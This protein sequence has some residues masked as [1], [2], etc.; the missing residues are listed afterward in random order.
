MQRLIQEE[1][2]QLQDDREVIAG[3]LR[4]ADK[5][6]KDSLF[7]PVN[8][9]RLIRTHIRGSSIDTV[10]GV[11]DLR[12]DT[13]IELVRELCDK[14]VVVRG[15]D[16][17]SLEANRN[18]TRLFKCLVRAELSS[19]RVI[20][21]HRMTEVVLRNV[22]GDVENKFSRSY[23]PPGDL[24]GVLAAQSIGEPTTQMTLNTFHN[25]G[26][27]AKNVTLG[28]PRLTELMSIAK[29]I[30]TPQLTI[31]VKEHLW[32][33]EDAYS[34]LQ[35]KLEYARL[36][37]LVK[38]TRIYYDPDAKSSVIA[39]DREWVEP[40]ALLEEGEVNHSGLGPWVL[41]LE[42]GRA[43]LDRAKIGLEDI[44]EKILES[45]GPNV[46]VLYNSDQAEKPVIRLR[47]FTDLARGSSAIDD[48]DGALGIEA[49]DEAYMKEIEDTLLH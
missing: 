24:A 1:Y 4:M 12:P 41:R 44:K 27:A 23:A 15:D 18:A 38:E 20:M 11:S 14:L 8:M 46:H 47:V 37:K 42:L 6:G 3:A 26:I 13:V 31:F 17:I 25:A 7:M 33:D 40:A 10:R 39:Q 9:S 29:N 2:D 16:L 34:K 43:Q 30:K 5:V 32:K 48:D 22:I 36:S 21:R 28:V 35:V 49:D 45:L 19:K